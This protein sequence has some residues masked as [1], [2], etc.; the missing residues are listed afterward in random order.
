MR[1]TLE[2]KIRDVPRAPGVYVM[3]DKDE[4]VIYVG[5]ARDLKSRVRAYFG[6]TDSRFMV[7]F[8]VSRIHDVEF[9]ITETEKEALIL[10]N[11]LIK[12]HRPRYN[13]NFRDDKA[14]FNIRINLNDPFPRF[15]LVRR[16]KKDGARYFGPYPSSAAAKETLHFLQQVFPLRT[17]RDRELKSRERACLEYQ[18]KRCLAPCIGLIDGE[19][20]RRLAKDGVAFLEGRENK[21]IADLRC[22][23]NS[24]AEH[25]NFEEA[26]V[27]RDRIAAI[28][29]TLEKQRIVS[30]SFKDQDVFGLYREGDL[31]QICVL[32]IRKGK[33]LGKKAFPLF[34]V[35]A[36]IKTSEILSSLLKQYYDGGV[37]IPGKI[38]IPDDMEDRAVME[39]WLAE[40]RGEIVSIVV[41]KR[42][43]GMDILRVARRNAENIFKT[44][45]LSA[46]NSEETIRTL[47]G[48]LRL[49]KPPER[50][51]CFDISD[52]GGQYAVGSMVT[53]VAGNPWKGGYK[54]FKIKTVTGADDY[55]MMYEVLKRR[56]RS[57]ENLPDLIMVDGGKGQLGVAVSVLRDLGIE[58]IDVIS[59]AKGEKGD[60][61]YLPQR[62]DPLYLSRWPACLFL[63]Q[64]V[65]DE[66]HRFAISYHRNLK[67]KGDFQSVLDEIPGIGGDRKRALLSFF[68]DMRK[69]REAPVEALQ[70]IDGIG[71]HTAEKIHAF[72]RGH[73]YL[74]KSKKTI[75]SP[76]LS[77]R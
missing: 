50:I 31:T 28:E 11:N 58:G 33:L 41:P 8:L 43:Q 38:I 19:A 60:R 21:L 40:K 54:R 29:R 66:A 5:K 30:M 22:Q 27:L 12:E 15:Q 59:L 7:P 49:R 67:E 57:R 17:C 51:E 65:R 10:E 9:I 61:V 44:E 74:P 14:Y 23:M 26:A 45:Y 4:R 3:K 39:E 76:V 25:L 47:A 36:G 24:A 13:V 75:I 52:I 69:I 77:I 32:Y 73:Q 18:T 48:H 63:L 72:L 56:Y 37:F 6:G 46:D 55:G 20:Y 2:S 16:V 62:K 64:R 68:G 1:N 35:R 53:F 70:Q 42:G 34:K 71:K